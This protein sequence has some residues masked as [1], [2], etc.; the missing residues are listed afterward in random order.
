MEFLRTVTFSLIA[1]GHFFHAALAQAAKLVPPSHGIYHGAFP[2][3]S[4]NADNVTASDV[5][6]FESLARKQT[7]WVYFSNHWFGGIRFPTS[8]VAE[9]RRAGRIPF[10]RLM[11]WS[12]DSEGRPDP[13]YN[14]QAFVD[15][16][17]DSDIRAF[18][19]A[20][21]DSGTPLMMEFGPEANGSWFPWNGKWN[22]GG[23][24]TLY[25]QQMWPDGPSRF[26]DAYRRIV[27]LFREV[28]TEN[29]TWVFHIDAQ[30][31]PEVWW[32][33]MSYY[34]PGDEY[35][36]WIGVS[37]FGAQLPDHDWRQL[38]DVLDPVYE[39]I[40]QIS[41]TKPIAL[42]EFGVID[43]PD[44]SHKA[45]WMQTA[46][47]DIAHG[48]YPRMKAISYWNSYGWLEDGSANM[49]IDSSAETLSAYR[50]A[51]TNPIFISSPVFGNR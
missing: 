8:E 3:S 28:G 23:S 20:A 38:R 17:F 21:R 49:R 19:R 18:A 40:L 15:G 36:D 41:K 9:I 46:L 37:A 14:M 32:N 10:L 42:V 43:K 30:P 35:I 48:R 27:R 34:Y 16:K 5:A 50:R 44:T 29:V 12:E 13:I 1:V 31:E 25:P 7:T 51:M 47:S 4:G 26:R 11:P 24:T 33:G 22:G 6:S 2:G 45:R 39:E